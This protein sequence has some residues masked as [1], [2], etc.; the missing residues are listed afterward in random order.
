[1][2]EQEQQQSHV[3]IDIETLGL[4]INSDIIAIGVVVFDA[5]G[6]IEQ[7]EWFCNLQD[8]HVDGNTL[9]WHLNSNAKFIHNWAEAEK[10]ALYIAL[11]NLAKVI[12]PTDIVWCKSTDFDIAMIRYWL[13]KF[14]LQTPWHYRNIR[15]YR[16]TANLFPSIAMKESYA[17]HSA[18]NDCMNQAEHLIALHDASNVNI[19]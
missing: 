11:S 3:M 2:K 14:G 7:H 8:S 13:N 19:L 1:M 15:D 10:V 12:K 18:L 6:I 5:H 17:K 9:Q 16:T 4:Q